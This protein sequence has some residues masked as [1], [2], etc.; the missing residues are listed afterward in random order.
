MGAPEGTDLVSA[1]AIAEREAERLRDRLAQI[2]LE[3]V[4]L[5]GELAA[6]NADYLRT[7]GVVMAQLDDVEARLLS[8][9]AQRSGARDDAEAAQS[10]AA[11]ARRTT[12][13]A[14]ALPAPPGPAPTGDLKK[15]FREAAKRMH[16]DLA[17]DAETRGHAEAFMKRLNDAYRAG[18]ADAIADLQRQWEASP[19]SVA[20]HGEEGR[21]VR[22]ARRVGA[23]HTAVERAQRRLD[24]V[25]ASELAELMERAMASAV[26]GT[27]LLEEMRRAAEAAL[28]EARV[29]LAAGG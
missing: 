17:P 5:E 11:R 1:A 3:Q 8:L 25:R 24:E 28:T 19:H 23:L 16:P 18:D 20:A 6:F 10:A 29:R 7:V 21:S 22:A 4:T 9:A 12:A 27:D 14:A 2:E 26:D 15:R 13:A